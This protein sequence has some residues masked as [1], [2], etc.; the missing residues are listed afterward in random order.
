MFFRPLPALVIY[1]GHTEV[2]RHGGYASL[3]YFVE[4]ALIR[5][6][7]ADAETQIVDLPL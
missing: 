5:H 7:A 4:N 1:E 3:A 6:I 2:A